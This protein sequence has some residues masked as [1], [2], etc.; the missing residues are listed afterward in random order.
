[1][2]P[3]ELVED[4]HAIFGEHPARAVQAKGIVLDATFEPTDQAD[5]LRKA[6]LFAGKVKAKACCFSPTACPMASR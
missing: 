4:I 5:Q 1:V 6:A 3:A 2:D